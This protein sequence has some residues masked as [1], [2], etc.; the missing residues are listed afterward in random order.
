MV[1]GKQ[2]SGEWANGE[3]GKG[4]IF[5]DNCENPRVANKQTLPW[6]KMSF[7]AID[8]HSFQLGFEVLKVPKRH[9]AE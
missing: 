9:G 1:R 8:Q 7:L 4:L 2:S 3:L 6:K 5:T